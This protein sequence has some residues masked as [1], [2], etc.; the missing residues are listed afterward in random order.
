MGAE[1]ELGISLAAPAGSPGGGREG[2]VR[3]RSQYGN[4]T[5][6]NHDNQGGQHRVF[7]RGRPLF[8]FEK[9]RY[10]AGEAVWHEIT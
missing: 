5:E 8:A 3:V 9:T 1:K 2:L 4:R 6:T 7:D 10:S